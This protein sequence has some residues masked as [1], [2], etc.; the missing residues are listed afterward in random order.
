MSRK[1]RQADEGG[2][3]AA[4]A[5]APAESPAAP[6]DELTLLR[7]EVDE[8]RDKNLRL[9]AELQ[10]Q[11][12]RAQRESQEAQRFAEAE[13]A[14]ELLVVLD[15]LERAQEAARNTQDAQAVAAGVRLVSEH[16]LKVLRDHHV[17]PIEAVGRPFDPA[18]HEALLQVPSSEQAA[19]IVLQEVARGYTLHERVLR[20]TRV[21]V[22]SGPPAT[23][24]PAG[25]AT[26]K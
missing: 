5:A 24:T 20:P 3:G 6:D 18:F 10:N 23:D 13:L 19:G 25:G 14:R 12:K 4:P 26:E 17:A 7:R 22:S 2:A 8:L 21:I 1:T 15:D 16:F 9:L 11:Q